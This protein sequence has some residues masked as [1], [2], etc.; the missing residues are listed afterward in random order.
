MVGVVC[1][2]RC[3]TSARSVLLGAEPSLPIVSSAHVSHACSTACDVYGIQLSGLISCKR[4]HEKILLSY[5]YARI[6]A[7]Q[8]RVTRFR[9]SAIVKLIDL[10][11]LMDTS[12]NRARAVL[13]VQCV[14]DAA[15]RSLPTALPDLVV[16]E[17]PRPPFD[18]IRVASGQWKLTDDEYG[19]LRME[20]ERLQTYL[21]FLLPTQ[22]CSEVRKLEGI[23][24][25]AQGAILRR[26][27]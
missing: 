12:E 22:E 25:G 15:P 5:R 14:F 1:S 3:E 20:T 4:R 9:D 16:S 10:H 21:L 24:I 2:S 23:S 19:D 26:A 8:A 6:R 18:G 13:P 17:A 11:L 7:V 27:S